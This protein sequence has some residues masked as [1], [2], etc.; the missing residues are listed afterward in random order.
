MASDILRRQQNP[1]LIIP[2]QT[3]HNLTTAVKTKGRVFEDLAFLFIWLSVMPLFSC[4]EIFARF[5][6]PAEKM[7]AHPRN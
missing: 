1:T 4:S 3:G 6:S 5:G 7:H 2:A